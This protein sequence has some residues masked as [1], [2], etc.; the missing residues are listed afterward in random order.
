MNS[1]QAKVYATYIWKNLGN[2][3]TSDQKNIINDLFVDVQMI[4]IKNQNL[5]NVDKVKEIHSKNLA[6][7]S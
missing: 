1:D 7:A 4:G 6:V 3:L 5:K 2:N